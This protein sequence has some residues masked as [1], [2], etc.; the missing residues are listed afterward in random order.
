MADVRIALRV[1]RKNPVYA[2]VAI[3]TLAVGIGAATTIFSVLN[4][5]V[6]QPVTALRHM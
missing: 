1:L 4:A 5:V 3:L 2:L 6:L